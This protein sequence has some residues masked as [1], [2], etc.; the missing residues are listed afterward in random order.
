MIATLLVALTVG[1]P[2]PGHYYRAAFAEQVAQ[3]TFD[4]EA[5]VDHSEPSLRWTAPRITIDYGQTTETRALRSTR[6]GTTTA[7]QSRAGKGP[8][9]PLLVRELGPGRIETDVTGTREVWVRLPSAFPELARQTQEA[10]TAAQRKAL[11]GRYADAE[12]HVLA[13]GPKTGFKLSHCLLSCRS[14]ARSW[15]VVHQRVIYRLDGEALVEVGP[16]GGL[17]P[18]GLAYE[19]KTDGK[20]FTRVAQ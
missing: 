2:Q 20:R 8:W 16:P 3:G 18:D 9:T 1:A 12:G 5:Y 7:W 15:C 4:P 19:P 10:R 11:I 14:E 17:C 6:T 13:L